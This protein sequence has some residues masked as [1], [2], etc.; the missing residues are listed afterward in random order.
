MNFDIRVIYIPQA[1]LMD[2]LAHFLNNQHYQF[3][4]DM[5]SH[6]DDQIPWKLPRS[7]QP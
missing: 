7:S 3:K 4:T 5:T 6:F 2:E 1:P